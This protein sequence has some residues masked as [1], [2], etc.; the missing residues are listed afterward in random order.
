MLTFSADFLAQRALKRATRELRAAIPD[1]DEYNEVRNV[2]NG[3]NDIDQDLFD[4]LNDLQQN[5][6]TIYDKVINFTYEEERINFMFDFKGKTDKL[7][8]LEDE[9]DLIDAWADIKRLRTERNR[10][11]FLK[12]YKYIAKTTTRNKIINHVINGEVRFNAATG[13]RK[14]GGYHL[15]LGANGKILD[16]IYTDALGHK[17]P[18]R[19]VYNFYQ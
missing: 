15:E 13:I 12:S 19:K 14:V 10:I 7:K 3:I 2:V 6:Q 5:R 17:I 11:S 1:G 9:I 8:A 4:F 18:L 16:T